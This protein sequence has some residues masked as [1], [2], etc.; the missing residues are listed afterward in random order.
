MGMD[1]RRRPV[2]QRGAPG[3]PIR[4]RY[5]DADE[6]L[7]YTNRTKSP[8]IKGIWSGGG[9]GEV[10]NSLAGRQVLEK[11]RWAIHSNACRDESLIPQDLALLHEKQICVLYSEKKM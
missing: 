10:L 4:G 2:A 3:I 7:V 9:I 6:V 8:L 11:A 5:V 1:L